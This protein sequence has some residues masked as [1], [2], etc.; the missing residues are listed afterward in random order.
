MAND[1]S[2]Y[3]ASTYSGGVYSPYRALPDGNADTETVGA[4]ALT[5]AITA[6]PATLVD[7][8]TTGQPDSSYSNGLIPSSIQDGETPGAAGVAF[9]INAAPATIA[10][11]ETFGGPQLTQTFNGYS[12]GIY[13]TGTYGGVANT[14]APNSLV[15]PDTTGAPAATTST[16]TSVGYG[17][18]IYSG[19]TYPGTNTISPAG[20]TDTETVGVPGSGGIAVPTTT[21][22]GSG[23]YG[24]GEYSGTIKDPGGAGIFTVP[25]Y[26]NPM[27]ILAIGPWNP[28]RV[29]RGAKN[30]GIGAGYAPARPHLQLP[31]VQSKSFTLRLYD[32]GEATAHLQFPRTAAV[33]VEEMSTDLW[34]RRKDPKTGRLE[35]VARYN[36]SHNDLS[37]GDDGTVSSSLQF[38]DYRTL[39]SERMVLKY[40]TTTYAKDGTIATQTSGWDKGTPI[41]QIMRFAVPTGMGIELGALDNDD[42]LGATTTA[43]DLPPATTIDKLFN[44]LLAVSPKPWEWWVDTPDDVTLPPS[45]T[46]V[47][48]KRGHNK[49]VTLADIGA[50]P[51]PIASWTMRATSDTYANTV[52]FQGSEGGIVTKIPAQISQYGERDTQVSDNT[53]GGN[54]ALLTAAARTRLAKLADRDPTFTVVLRPGFWRGRSHID[55][56]DVITLRIHLGGEQLDYTYRV[57]ELQ[58]DI[59]TNGVE[60]ITLT[61]GNPLASA[62]GRSRQSPLF[63]VIRTLRDYETPAHSTTNFDYDPNTDS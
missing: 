39:L 12:T 32:G 61:L 5:T 34:W 31:G 4:P 43:F 1:Q 8:E 52:Y 21:G 2:V 23:V 58:A 40:L 25:V 37:R 6:A 60:T 18:G 27:H 62:N 16:V 63:K 26:G 19:G 38:V 7:A 11:T 9:T 51:T 59:D 33:V 48:G 29:W 22:Y 30:Y 50:G 44:A 35:M 54:L 3:G 57:T 13:G 45:L 41:T 20:I 36:T 53:V 15:D 14:I 28:T 55:V 10:G 42:L 46:F 24:D 17:A 47:I 56:G 49:G